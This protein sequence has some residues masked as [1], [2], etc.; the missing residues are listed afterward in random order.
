MWVVI[1]VVNGTAIRT[2]G[3]AAVGIASGISKVAGSG[4]RDACVANKGL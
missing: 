1:G 3:D 2:T 4:A